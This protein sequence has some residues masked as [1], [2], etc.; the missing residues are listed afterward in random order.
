MA[1]N[2]EHSGALPQALHG[3]SLP[4]VLILAA[5]VVGIA[6]LLPLLQNSIATSTGGNISRLEQEREDWRARLHEQ[7]VHVAQLGSLDRIEREARARLKMTAPEEVIHLNVDAPPP[8]PRRLPSR[9][10][11][12]SQQQPGSGSSLWD[13]LTGWIP[14]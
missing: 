13:D 8:A 7:E 10:L 2:R 6:A 3:G 1:S 11:P 12:H 14:F 4:I 5:M 9:F